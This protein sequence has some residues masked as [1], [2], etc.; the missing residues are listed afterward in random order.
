M[1]VKHDSDSSG[2]KRKTSS[3]NMSKY[4]LFNWKILT[5]KFDNFSSYSMNRSTSNSHSTKEKPPRRKHDNSSSSSS[6]SSSSESDRS[7]DDR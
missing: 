5:T 6:S 3:T 2:S 7:S 4:N 1:P